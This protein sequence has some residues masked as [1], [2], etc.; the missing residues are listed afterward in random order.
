[1]S[2]NSGPKLVAH[3]GYSLKYP[4]NTLLSINQAFLAGACYVECDVQ[5]TLDGVP[6]LLHDVELQRTTDQLGNV[7]EL[8]LAQV[9]KAS[10]HFAEKFGEQFKPEPIPTLN[11]L[12]SLMAQWPRRHVFVEIK[13][14]TI[15]CY[16]RESVLQNIA[17]VIKPIADQVTLI[18]FDLEIMQ[19]ARSTTAFR[20][21]WVIEEWSSNNLELAAQLQPDYMFVDYE[22]IPQQLETLPVADWHWVVYEIDD[23]PTAS[24]WLEKGAKLIETNDIGGLLAA[25]E[26]KQSS[27]DD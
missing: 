18:S 4:E 22:C 19:L 23:V 15:R 13:R 21:G 25:P 27:C 9:N 17:E 20:T 7:N 3:R 10:A 6:V 2:Q 8:N 5:L 26:F 24:L 14:A 16:G 1:M 11:Q 12:V